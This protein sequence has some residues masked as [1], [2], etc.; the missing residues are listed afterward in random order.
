MGREGSLSESSWRWGQYYRLAWTFALTGQIADAHRHL[1]WL[2]NHDLL[3]GGVLDVREADPHFPNCTSYPL[4]CI[5]MSASLLQRYDILRATVP[6]L[7]TWQ[8][9]TSGGFVNNKDPLQPGFGDQ[10]LFPTAQGGMTLV[11]LGL[12]DPARRVGVW[13]ENLWN[14]QPNPDKELY[15]VW[16]QEGGLQ[17]VC[18]PGMEVTMVTKK[19]SAWEWHFDGGIAAAFLAKLFMATGE[20]RWLNLAE[21]YQEFS[22]TS[23]DEM[24]HSWQTCKS[25]WGAGMLFIATGERKFLEWTLRMADWFVG[26]QHADG[27]WAADFVP[28]PPGCPYTDEQRNESWTI[29]IVAEVAMHMANIV[30][31]LSTEGGASSRL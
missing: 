20:N 16:R 6:E 9:E 5:I 15:H 24:F 4:S 10:V 8:D 22:M 31:A 19:H 14:A 1:S 25:G 29:H 27:C 12:L 21:K 28:D 26:R 23:G 11:Q 3:A 18:E 13:F 2:A 17:T 30:A 7:L